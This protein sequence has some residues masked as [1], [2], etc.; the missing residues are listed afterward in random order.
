MTSYTDTTAVNGTTY[1]YAVRAVNPIGPGPLS[2]EASATPAAP[3]TAPGAPTLAPATAG[4]ASVAL[5]WT[6]GSTGGAAI[7]NYRVYR[8]TTSGNL[9]LLTTLGAVASYTDTAVANGTTYVYQVSAVNSVGEGPRS[10]ERSA[11]PTA[12]ATVPGAPQSLI[13]VQAARKGVDIEWAPPTSTGG[14]PITGYRIY[15][16]TTP[17]NGTL[18]TALGN[19]VTYRDTATK[20]GIRY[21]L[22]RAGGETP[23]AK[24]RHRTRRTPSQSRRGPDAA[25]AF[26]II[27]SAVRLPE[28]H[29]CANDRS[30]PTGDH[31]IE[32]SHGRHARSTHH[33]HPDR[34]KRCRHVGAVS[35]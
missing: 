31:E 26:G 12:P 23:W 13:A 20:K 30:V 21:S 34:P 10:V 25:Q 8:G 33:R 7:T 16:G 22:R 9:A 4:D 2:G 28:P 35:R 14:S 18:L 1:V 3:A 29:R 17:A 5:S 27:G 19:F 32:V 15:R 6:P 11:T 24:G